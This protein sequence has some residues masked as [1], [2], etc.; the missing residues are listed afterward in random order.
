MRLVCVAMFAMGCG[1]VKA[2]P[3]AT[4]PSDAPIRCND[5]TRAA[6]EVCF[7]ALTIEQTATVIDAQFADADGDGDLDLGYVL[8]DKLA[9]QFQNAGAFGAVVTTTTQPTSFLV[10]RDLTG[11]R[12]ADMVSAGPGGPTSLVTFLGDGHGVEQ[13]VYVDQTAGVPRGLALANIDGVGPDELVEFDDAKLQV[14]TVDATAV[15]TNLGGGIPSAGLT[16]GAVGKVDGDAFADVVVATP[17]GI[18]LR[19]GMA[20]GLGTAEPVGVNQTATALATG[21]VDGDGKLDIVYA[22]NGVVGV[23][24]GNGGG[25]FT[26]GP[27]KPLPGAG[28]L[29][30]LADIDGDGRADVISPNGAVLEISLGQ[31]DGSFGD[32]HEITLT[33]TPDFIHV[34]MDFNSD[35]APDIVVTSGKT[36]TILVSQ[37]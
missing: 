18:F 5:G 7:V 17:A 9:L 34:D 19:R 26:A 1:V 33:G 16:A 12:N 14:W 32:P 36:I 8:G 21:D 37:P 22:L 13:T 15:I 20:L 11:D 27:T 2:L 4:S 35:H 23:M 28:R 31:P 30:E 29:L 10:F 25:G 24:R 3:D 6:G